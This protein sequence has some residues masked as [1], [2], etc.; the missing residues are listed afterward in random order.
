MIRTLVHR[1]TVRTL[2][3]VVERGK[4]SPR[5]AVRV[6]AGALDRA[7]ATLGLRRIAVRSPVPEWTGRAAAQ[8]M[9]ASDRIKLEK[10]RADRGIGGPAAAAP[11]TAPIQLYFKRGCPRTRAARGLL[12]ERELAYE[13]ID[14]TDDETRRSWLSLVTR[15]KKT[16]Q[17]FVLG[18]PIG[19]FDELREL[20]QSGELARRL[21]P[22]AAAPSAPPPVRRPVS[23]AGRIKLPI[24][25]PER[26][27]FEG[28]AEPDR[29]DAASDV[30][31]LEGDALVAR[32]K[33]ILDECRPLVQ[34]DGG[35]IVLLDVT[36]NR[37][38]LE[39]TGNCVGCPS[40]Q[41]TLHQGIERRRIGS[42]KH[43]PTARSRNV[44]P[45]AGFHGLF[46]RQHW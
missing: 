16:P 36:T 30:E 1:I 38:T 39:L 17:V 43:L 14:V 13:A 37:V 20:D 3:A 46:C 24:L 25:H 15:S 22:T 10:H 7:R 2:D 23:I 11:P 45:S 26:S 27:P 31:R 6:A 5:G 32:V 34:A 4:A 33:E 35:D 42:M 28:E 9:W 41:A 44:R 12:D 8:P 29:D 18:E 19:G 40:A 21:A